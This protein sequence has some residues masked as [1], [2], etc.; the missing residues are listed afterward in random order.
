MNGREALKLSIN[1]AKFVC[2]GYLGDLTEEELMKRPCEGCNH[3]KWQVGHLIASEHSMI[4]GIAPGS[5]PEL[6]AGFA[7]KYTKE[8]A[9][10]DNPAD[11]HSKDQLLST[12]ES[13]RAATLAALD[14]IT[15]ADLDKPTGVHYAETVGAMYELQGS[16][17]LMHSGQWAVVRRQCGRAPLF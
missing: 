11:F 14:K 7:E 15:D 1:M 12:F 17:W 8:T 5:M 10:S 16:H 4:S 3:I 9:K 13:V 6:P 2:M